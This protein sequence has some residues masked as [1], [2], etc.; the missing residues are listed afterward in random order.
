MSFQEASPF[1]SA[2][3]EA[4]GK[5]C[6]VLKPRWN[7]FLGHSMFGTRRDLIDAVG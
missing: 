6:V 4:E 2:N 1:A 3:H 7:V 5:R